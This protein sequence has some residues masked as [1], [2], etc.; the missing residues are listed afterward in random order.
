[1]DSE[2]VSKWHNKSRIKI[3]TDIHG[4]IDIQYII[5]IGDKMADLI[6]KQDRLIGL[7]R[8][9]ETLRFHPSPEAA[10]RLREVNE[11]IKQEETDG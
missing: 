7:Y 5:E 6:E 9:R 10:I 4:A 2:M 1:M 11:E 8:L 3:N